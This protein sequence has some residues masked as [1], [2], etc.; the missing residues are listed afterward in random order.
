LIH[1][2]SEKARAILLLPV[3]RG[4]KTP[5]MPTGFGIHGKL[6]P[7]EM[8]PH[9]GLAELAPPV[10]NFQVKNW[11]KT[12]FSSPSF[13]SPLKNRFGFFKERLVL[14]LPLVYHLRSFDEGVFI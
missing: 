1:H 11:I 7:L 14:H 9:A 12:A 10:I 13:K 3:C 8:I 5:E 2:G 6:H 4:F